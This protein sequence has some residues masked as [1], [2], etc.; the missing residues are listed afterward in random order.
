[1]TFLEY[2][3]QTFVVAFLQIHDIPNLRSADHV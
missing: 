3:T 1:M 2:V